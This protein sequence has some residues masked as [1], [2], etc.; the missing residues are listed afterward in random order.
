MAK[1]VRMADI[2]E[3]LG[4]SIVSVSKGLAGKDGVS[5]EMREK[6]LETAKEMGYLPPS[7]STAAQRSITS[8]SWWPTAILGT[9]PSTPISTSRWSATATG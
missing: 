2:A 7:K 1:R 6:I 3:K 8:A 5:E 9:T 4:I